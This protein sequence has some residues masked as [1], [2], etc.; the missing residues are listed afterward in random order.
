ML[1]N[2]CY[3]EQNEWGEADAHEMT[4]CKFSGSTQNLKN[5]AC[6]QILEIATFSL[7]LVFN[8]YKIAFDVCLGAIFLNYSKFC[9]IQ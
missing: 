6:K 3:N 9:R 8:P 2:S 1:K 7:E 5:I 4:Y